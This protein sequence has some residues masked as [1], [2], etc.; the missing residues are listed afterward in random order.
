MKISTISYQPETDFIYKIPK[1]EEKRPQLPVFCEVEDEYV[2][3]EDIPLN[4]RNFVYTPCSGN[5]LFEELKFST[6]EY[7]F[8]GAGFS[9]MD[10]SDDLLLCQ[11]SNRTICVPASSG[12]RSGRCEAAIKEGACYWEVEICNGGSPAIEEPTSIKSLKEKLNSTPHVRLGISRREASLEA[13]VGF[14]SYSYGLRD[15]C[16]ESVHQGKL[17][18]VLPVQHLKAGDVVGLLLVLPSVEEQASQSREYVQIKIDALAEASHRDLS[19]ASS[20]ENPIKRKTRIMNREFQKALLLEH[21]TQNVVRDQIAIRYKNQLFFETTDYIKTTKPEYYTS[22]KRER[23]EFHTL[24]NSFLK[25]FVNGQEVGKA[26][27]NLRPFLPPFSELKY[28]EKFY[29]NYWRN[30]T[31]TTETRSEAKS[32]NLNEHKDSS[33]GLVSNNVIL[34]NKYVNNSKLGYYP[35]V[36]CFNGGKAKIATS[37]EEMRYFDAVQ[38]TM[39]NVMTPEDLFEHQVADDVVWD[40]IDEVEAEFLAD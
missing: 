28:N 35:T 25:V 31:A 3:P 16:L 17:S 11:G 38:R 4:R 39:A 10:R 14:D 26:F 12:W 6:T 1:T 13:P 24:N 5:P 40:V 20:V 30:G 32:E 29:F 15:N 36:S 2:K 8:N 23:E 27:E 33:P 34:R 19:Q 18:Q 21:D 7:D 37:Q 22:D 9:L